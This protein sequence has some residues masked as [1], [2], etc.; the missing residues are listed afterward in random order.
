MR[1]YIIYIS[2]HFIIHSIFEN[3]PYP[4]Y[5]PRHKVVHFKSRSVQRIILYL[6]IRECDT[7]PCMN[8]ARCVELAGSYECVCQPGYSGINC[9][10]GGHFT[11]NQTVNF[12]IETI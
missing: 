5:I 1:P 12:V 9:A 8:N 10:K 11:Y 3:A 2:I 4:K 7:N 6:D